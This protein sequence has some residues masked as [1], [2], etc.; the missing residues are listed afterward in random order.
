M[1]CSG[2]FT[3]DED[4]KE[5]IIVC[6]SALRVIFA[7][8]SRSLSETIGLLMEVEGFQWRLLELFIT[9]KLQYVATNNSQM[10]MTYT[11]LDIPRGTKRSLAEPTICISLNDYLYQ[12]RGQELGAIHAGTL[13]I[14]YDKH[15]VVDLV[16]FTGNEELL[17]LQI[18]ESAYSDHRT[19]YPALFKSLVAGTNESI[20]SYYAN[21]A[22]CP[23]HKAHWK[24][25]DNLQ[26][27]FPQGIY[28]VYITTS[29]KSQVRKT[30]TFYGHRGFVSLVHGDHL[31]CF[32]SLY[33]QFLAK[34]E[35]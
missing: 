27:K 31:K 30:S 10:Q 11:S 26:Y 20:L 34:K 21:R 14:C 25:L 5:Y 19:K 18:S 7:E 35:S 28:Y 23:S 29:P 2:L 16:V 1:E 15:P 22:I 12:R 9:Q 8:L 33:K 24:N 13:I 4:H 6:P 32:G 17:F 3:W